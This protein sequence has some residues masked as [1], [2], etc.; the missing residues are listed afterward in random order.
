MDRPTRQM[1]HRPLE[2]LPRLWIEILVER[3]HELGHL[4]TQLPGLAPDLVPSLQ[5]SSELLELS[6]SLGV[7][8]DAGGQA[9]HVEVGFLSLL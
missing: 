4:G 5:Q 7:Q 2:L 3:A 1:M 8:L 6:T 9:V